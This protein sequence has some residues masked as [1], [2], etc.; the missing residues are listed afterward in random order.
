[1]VLHVSNAVEQ[2]LKKRDGSIC[3]DVNSTDNTEI[4]PIAY[5]VET[6]RGEHPL[7]QSKRSSPAVNRGPG[8]PT[9]SP[10]LL[11][12]VALITI[13]LLG[14]YLENSAAYSGIF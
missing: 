4:S 2:L 8:R 7:M 6:P 1:M 5:A 12:Y 10:W 13:P 11:L 3:N 9:D 14:I